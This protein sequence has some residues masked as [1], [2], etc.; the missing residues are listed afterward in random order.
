MFLLVISLSLDFGCMW[1]FLLAF[2]RV[3]SC[4]LVLDIWSIESAYLSID[5]LTSGQAVNS[6]FTDSCALS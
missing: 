4:Q 6:I 1:V 5:D 3:T 2:T